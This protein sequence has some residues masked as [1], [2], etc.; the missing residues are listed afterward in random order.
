MADHQLH[1]V[2]QLARKGDTVRAYD[3]IQ[4]ITRREPENFQAWMWQA[5]VAHTNNEKRAALRRALL[6]RPNDDSIR[7]MLRQLTAP[8]HIRRAARSGIFMGYARADELFAVDLT[9]SLRA[10]GIETWLD[11]TEIGLD[12]WHGSV[13]RALMR[14]GL[15]LLVLSPEA[16]RSEQ[17]RSEFAW[18]RQTGK[19]ILPALHKACDYSAL[20]LLCPAIDFM[21]DYAQG[22]QQLIRLLT[23]EQSAENS[24]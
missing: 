6:L 17:L 23:T 5:Y 15:M 10:N 7:A 4:Q 11:M 18:F 14:S 2:V 24:A 1:E 19:I 16:L 21:D 13:T 22:L 9:D 20:D 12:T 3:L 8:K